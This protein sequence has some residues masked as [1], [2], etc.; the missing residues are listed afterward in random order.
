LKKK[1]CHIIHTTIS[2][3]ENERRI[4][5]EVISAEKSGYRVKILAL[6]I[7]GIP[8]KDVI[9]HSGIFR[10]FIKYWKGSPLKFIE[11][12]C[13]L[14]FQ[15]K[16]EKFK[17]LH[18]HD[19]WVLPAT[20]MAAFFAK[21]PVIYDVHEYV[22]G[23]E[24]FNQKKI[25]GF[26]WKLA[27]R[28]YIRFVRVIIVINDYHGRLLSQVYPNIPQPHFL[29][30]FPSLEMDKHYHQRDF[31][32]R[33]KKAVYQGILKEGR[34]LG[35][36]IKSMS[37]M[38]AGFL[39]IVGYGDLENELKTL[40]IELNLH[41]KIKFA[42]KINWDKLIEK[43]SMAR[44]GLVLFEP[45]GLNYT[46]ASPNKFFEYVSAGTPVIASNIPSFKDLIKKFEV[47]IL[48]DHTS[49]SAIAKSIENLLTN[50]NTWAKFHSECLKARREWNWERQEVELLR[51]YKDL[52]NAI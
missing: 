48:V 17:I 33:D 43:T 32:Q 15:L 24:I 31:N 45:D 39:E 35:R 4:F 9:S 46:Y 30:N 13:K 25:S 50:R 40:V 42:G 12:N 5:N 6:H 18:A 41:E 2:P 16:R 29:M 3:C 23:L 51:I 52:V 11:F 44:A 36:V 38:Q 26:I 8:E 27:E 49:I 10:L 22:R 14:F 19:L 7:P 47:G 28:I 20:V 37:S 34:N 21:K 1:F